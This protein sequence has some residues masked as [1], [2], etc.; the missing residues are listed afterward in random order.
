MTALVFTIEGD[1]SDLDWLRTRIEG[2]IHEVI[3]EDV[4]DGRLAE[5]LVQVSWTWDD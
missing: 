1:A 4:D 2:A 5:G 3:D